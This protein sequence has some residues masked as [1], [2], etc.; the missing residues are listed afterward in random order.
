MIRYHQ[1]LTRLSPHLGGKWCQF[2]LFWHF[3]RISLQPPNWEDPEHRQKKVKTW[4]THPTRDVIM[5]RH[6]LQVICTRTT[7]MH[8]TKS[9]TGLL[10]GAMWTFGSIGTVIYVLFCN[11]LTDSK[12]ILRL[13][14]RILRKTSQK[15]PAWN[16]IFSGME[17]VMASPKAIPMRHQD[18]MP[19]GSSLYAHTT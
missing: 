1:Q 14:K 17:P 2:F 18:K 9:S 4:P 8:G 10:S 16:I 19:S 12:S 5:Q 3:F 7:H 15:S 11:L 6:D 13:D